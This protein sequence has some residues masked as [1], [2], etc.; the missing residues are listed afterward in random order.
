[1]NV[2]KKT[3]DD[4]DLRRLETI[5]NTR[6]WSKNKALDH[7]FG[8]QG[9]LYV[10]MILAL[11]T[12]ESLDSFTPEV[13][14]KARFLKES[15]LKYETIL[16]AF[17]Y[18]HIFNI[19]GPLSR[20]LQTKGMDLIKSQELVN[21]SLEQLIKQ[22]R[23]MNDVKK[24]ADIFIKL[25]S[26]KFEEDYDL[27]VIIE[28]KFP[29]GRCR[30]KKKMYDESSLDTPI[31]NVEKRFEVQVHNV[32]LDTI[33]SSM[34]KKFYCNKKLFTDLSCLSPNNFEDIINKKLPSNALNVLFKALKYF[35]GSITIERLKN[36]L[37]SFAENWKDLKKVLPEEYVH[38]NEDI[39]EDSDDDVDDTIKNNNEVIM[40]SKFCKSCM[41][42]SVCCYNV[43]LKYNLYSDA[44]SHL[45]L[46]YKYLLTLPCTQ[47]PIQLL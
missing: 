16:T 4:K 35:D 3:I 31:Q 21:N 40:N 17:I 34:E 30:Y 39:V 25:V 9:K 1:M 42:C 10:E 11:D 47:V 36:E 37:I 43:L 8:D 2:W 19:V 44:Y 14:V 46:A 6:W 41:N 32:I 5:G 12:I 38:T 29:E 24:Q 13:R 26:T 28:T 20:Y 23:N 27:D 15:F 45:A 22:Q 7:I 18:V 33:I